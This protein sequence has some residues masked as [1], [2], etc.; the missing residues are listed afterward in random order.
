MFERAN[1]VH[2]G[3]SL[4]RGFMFGRVRNVFGRGNGAGLLRSHHPL[5]SSIKSAGGLPRLE[6]TISLLAYREFNTD[7]YLDGMMP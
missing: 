3:R 2:L 5:P 6:F 7:P 1:G 4:T